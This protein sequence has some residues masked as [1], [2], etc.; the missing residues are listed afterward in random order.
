MGPTEVVS[1]RVP[2]QYIPLL[3]GQD[4]REILIRGLEATLEK[5][6]IMAQENLRILNMKREEILRFKAQEIMEIDSQIS[7]IRS[8]ME[9]FTSEVLEMVDL[10]RSHVRNQYKGNRAR[11]TWSRNPDSY[12]DYMASKRPQDLIPWYQNQ[13]IG[14]TYGQLHEMIKGVEA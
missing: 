12:I 1:I 7:E 3:K 10:F 2:V 4:K 5:N 11:S 14:V 6:T 8:R 13:G 9:S